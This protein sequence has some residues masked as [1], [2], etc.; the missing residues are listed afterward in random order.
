MNA[1]GSYPFDQ[2]VFRRGVD[3]QSL[4]GMFHRLMM[5]GIHFDARTPE[6]FS[7]PRALMDEDPMASGIFL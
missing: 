2:S 5:R 4:A 7:E 6:D 3:D 1:V